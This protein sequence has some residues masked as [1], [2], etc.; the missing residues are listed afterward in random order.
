[1]PT[2]CWKG[3]K[4]CKAHQENERSEDSTETLKH[5]ALSSINICNFHTLFIFTYL[6]HSIVWTYNHRQCSYVNYIYYLWPWSNKIWF[7]Y[8]TRTKQRQY[9]NQPP[10]L[11]LPS[12]LS[13]PKG[14]GSQNFPLLSASCWSHRHDCGNGWKRL[15]TEINKHHTAFE[16]SLSWLVY[17]LECK[18]VVITKPPTATTNWNFV[19]W[20]HR[21]KFNILPAFLRAYYGARKQ[22]G[23][24]P[25]LHWA[26]ALKS[27][28]KVLNQKVTRQPKYFSSSDGLEAALE[29]CKI[30]CVCCSG[31]NSW[32]IPRLPIH[33]QQVIKNI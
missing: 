3:L 24:S 15:A 19:T 21:D 5:Y 14:R 32:N 16:K 33:S 13:D 9:M 12:I 29:P 30:S 2:K 11:D 18:V 10:D 17:N 27:V 23:D 22:K 4:I 31:I 28:A 1:M 7:Q 8:Y 20:Q 25:Y 6:K 26:V